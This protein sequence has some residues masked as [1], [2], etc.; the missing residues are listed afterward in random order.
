M[1]DTL[2]AQLVSS[3]P[4]K[5]ILLIEDIDCA[6]PSREEKE[7]SDKLPF[8]MPYHYEKSQVTMSGL[9]NILDGI[10]SGKATAW[11]VLAERKANKQNTFR[12]RQIIICNGC[13]DSLVLCMKQV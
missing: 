8:N 12:G 5:A 11:L 10:G 1:D 2:L 9:L 13:V 7:R 4:P 3:L 6:F